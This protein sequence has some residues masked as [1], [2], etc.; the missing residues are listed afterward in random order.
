MECF[1]RSYAGQHG[2]WAKRRHLTDSNCHS[3]SFVSAVAYGQGCYFAKDSS[4]SDGFAPPDAQGFRRMFLG[5]NLVPFCN[6]SIDLWI[7]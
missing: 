6:Q 3:L 1:N 5:M 2:S 7:L 4:Y